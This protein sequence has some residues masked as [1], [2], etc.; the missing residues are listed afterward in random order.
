MN[1]QV[2]KTYIYKSKFNGK[3]FWFQKYYEIKIKNMK[4]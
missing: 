1:Q 2:N 4:K 3:K